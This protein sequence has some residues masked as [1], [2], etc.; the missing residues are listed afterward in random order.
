[1]FVVYEF[2]F[3]YSDSRVFVLILEFDQVLL[4]LFAQEQ[5][6][7]FITDSLQVL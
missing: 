6:G 1:M 3:E 5:E 7:V 2:D 4:D